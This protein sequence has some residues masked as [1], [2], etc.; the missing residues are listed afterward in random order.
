MHAD[1]VN[2]NDS[3]WAPYKLGLYEKKTDFVVTRKKIKLKV[4]RHTPTFVFY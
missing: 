3:S 4:E 2:R 1:I